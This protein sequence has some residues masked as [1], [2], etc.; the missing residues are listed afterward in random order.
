MESRHSAR[1]SVT[2]TDI[3]QT[4][5]SSGFVYLILALIRLHI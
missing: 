4:L 3:D 2:Q 5:R 1:R